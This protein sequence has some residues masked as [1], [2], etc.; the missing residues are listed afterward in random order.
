MKHEYFKIRQLY[1][2]KENQIVADKRIFQA[3]I[4]E[5]IREFLPSQFFRAMKIFL[6]KLKVFLKMES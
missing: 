5:K 2:K 4:G 6:F 1:A 3:C